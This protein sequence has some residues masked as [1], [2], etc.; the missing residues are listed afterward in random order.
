VITYTIRD[1]LFSVRQKGGLP[2]PLPRSPRPRV[3]RCPGGL[4]HGHVC[5][6]LA[7][8]GALARPHHFVELEDQKKR[9]NLPQVHE[10][11]RL[12]HF[13]YCR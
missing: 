7:R 4:R 11:N 2:G 3:H 6:R 12:V 13:P 9:T 8:E 1:T 5:L 10:P